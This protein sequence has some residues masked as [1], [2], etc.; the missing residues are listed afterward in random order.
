MGSPTGRWIGLSVN[1]QL[2]LFT[3]GV[4][5]HDRNVIGGSALSVMSHT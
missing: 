2:Q 1:P 4:R 5:T 3:T